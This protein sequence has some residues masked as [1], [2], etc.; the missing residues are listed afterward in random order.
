MRLPFKKRKRRLAAGSVLVL[1][2]AVSPNLE[3][4]SLK[5]LP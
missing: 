5:G 3:S 2:A 4:R 1:S